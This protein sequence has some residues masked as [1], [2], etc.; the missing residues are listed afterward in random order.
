MEDKIKPIRAYYLV[1]FLI[2]GLL[3]VLF[4]NLSIVKEILFFQKGENSILIVIVITIILLILPKN[5]KEIIGKFTVPLLKMLVSSYNSKIKGSKIPN[6]FDDRN[7]IGGNHI[8]K[9]NWPLVFLTYFLATIFVVMV[10]IML[11]TL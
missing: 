6:S 10:I 4:L 8:I 1:V 11:L 7:S 5:I 9:S 2:F 3:L